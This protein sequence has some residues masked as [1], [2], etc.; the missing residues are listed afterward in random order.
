MSLYFFG[1]ALFAAGIGLTFSFPS[2]FPGKAI[3]A[4]LPIAGTL[5]TCG[6]T[7]ARIGFQAR[8]DSDDR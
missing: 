5:I 2:L 6:W 8:R 1:I 4:A 3:L 7:L